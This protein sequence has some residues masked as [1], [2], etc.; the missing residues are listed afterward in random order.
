MSRRACHS[1]ARLRSTSVDNN[2]ITD[3]FRW[4]PDSYSFIYINCQP[5]QIHSA[6]FLEYRVSISKN[7]RYG[8]LQFKISPGN[9]VAFRHKFNLISTCSIHHCVKIGVRKENQIRRVRLTRNFS[10]SFPLDK[11][12]LGD[13]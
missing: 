13:F 1:N 8:E 2:F 9:P 6:I 3:I 11:N 10:H 4:L 12:T 5:S 7:F